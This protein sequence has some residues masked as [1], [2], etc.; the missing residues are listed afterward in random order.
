[1]KKPA[2]TLMLTTVVL[3]AWLLSGCS[4]TQ[5]GATAGGLAG[6]AIGGS[7]GYSAAAT[8]TPAQ[9]ALIGA[10][11]GTAAGALIGDQFDQ[12]DARDAQRDLD[13]LRAQL[14]DR[15]NELAQ[16]KTDNDPRVSELET[17]RMQ[18]QSQLNDLGSQNSDL[19]QKLASVAEEKAQLAGEKAQMAERQ[20]ALSSRIV[21]VEGL[22]DELQKQIA[23]RENRL[24]TLQTSVQQKESNLD[25]LRRQL[26]ELNVQLDET[27]RGLTLTI[28]DQLLYAPGQAELTKDGK[29]LIAKVSGIIQRQ[30]PGREIIVEGHTD[31]QPIK[32]SGWKSNWEL[33]S[34]RA[35]AVVHCMTELHGFDPSRVSAMSFGEF[36]P[37]A[38]NSTPEGRSMNR[39]SVILIMPERMSFQKQV[40]AV[41]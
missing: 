16:L 19:S 3:T 29:N 1:M 34:A 41:Q 22:I 4:A 20:A 23:D 25:S 2:L 40:A 11:G 8:L 6:A 26:D 39:R 21:E 18:L 30:F 32:F 10:A 33:G 7:W 15:E 36:R 38:D 24:A 37:A 9:T 12:A 27:N 14:T 5:K 17:Q 35:L 31:N 13:N 28:L